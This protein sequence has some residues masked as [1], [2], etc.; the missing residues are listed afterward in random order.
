MRPGDQQL[1][2]EVSHKL[3]IFS[4]Q[5]NLPGIDDL[6]NKQ[7]LV[8]Q[9]IDSVRRIK[10]IR[11]IRDQDVSQINLNTSSVLFDPLKGAVYHKRRGNINEAFWLVFLATHFGKHKTQ[12]WQ[13]AEN[14]LRRRSTITIL[15]M[16]KNNG[17]P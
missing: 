16:G 6:Q 11:L 7:A 3:T 4:E 12:G 9:I 17:R 14:R 1:A 8:E 10:Y 13:L 5:Y 15:D 2:I